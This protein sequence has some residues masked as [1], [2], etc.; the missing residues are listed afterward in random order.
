MLLSFSP[1][2]VAFFGV[3]LADDDHEQ[4]YNWDLPFIG[5]SFGD[6]GFDR[7]RKMESNKGWNKEEG[8]IRQKMN[9]D[10]CAVPQK[11]ILCLGTFGT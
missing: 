3:T 2:I 5:V 9:M 1:P 8:L 6:D 11:L 4:K 10:V 7:V